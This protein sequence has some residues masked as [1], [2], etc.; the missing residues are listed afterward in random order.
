MADM[1]LTRKFYEF[2]L[3]G[4]SRALTTKAM[5]ATVAEEQPGNGG[6]GTDAL[7]K[8]AKGEEEET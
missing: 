1:G 6:R 2:S 4:R 7:T 3:W 5:G 8:D